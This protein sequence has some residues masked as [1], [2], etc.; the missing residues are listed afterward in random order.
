MRPTR[1]W[2]QY[3]FF[4]H[5]LY[6]PLEPWPLLFSFMIILQTVGLLGRVISSLQG[7]YLNTGQHEHRINTYTH[8]QN[9]HV[10]CGIRTNDPGFRES[11]DSTCLKRSLPWPAQYRILGRILGRI[12][13]NLFEDILEFFLSFWV[14]PWRSVAIVT[15]LTQINWS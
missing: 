4:F 1:N 5:W 8:T 10:F 14:S 9:I 3:R 2:T 6:S 13:L 15:F 12:R 11:E 7:L